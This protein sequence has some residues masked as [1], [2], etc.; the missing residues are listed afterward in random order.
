VRVKIAA[1]PFVHFVAS[2]GALAVCVGF[3]ACG[4]DDPAPEDAADSGAS[5][6]ENPTDASP[7]KDTGST[8]PIVIEVDCPVGTTPEVEPNDKPEQANDVDLLAFCGSI[9]TGTDVD[10]S[11]F[12]TPAGKKLV[13]FQAVIDGQIDFDLVVNG[14]TL[15]PADVKKFEA[16]SYVIKAYAKDTKPGKYKYRIQFEP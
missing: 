13:L 16:G 5:I 3:S 15:K 9:A 4:E 6:T 1:R 2:V 7:P 12:T 11:K 14:K 8:G 10:Y